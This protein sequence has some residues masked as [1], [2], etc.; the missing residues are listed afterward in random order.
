M[1]PKGFS[2]G[3]E[4]PDD[5]AGG[6]NEIFISDWLLLLAWFSQRECAFTFH[7]CDFVLIP[8]STFELKHIPSKNPITIES[9]STRRR[10][11]L[12][13]ILLNQ[14]GKE[15]KSRRLT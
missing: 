1:D 5:F 15:A 6:P 11:R 4:I 9:A 2:G 7:R 12:N 3:R 10:P 14:L 8:S 13:E